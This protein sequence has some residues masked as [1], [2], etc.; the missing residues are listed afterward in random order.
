MNVPA[1]EVQSIK[2]YK[3]KQSEGKKILYVETD[4]ENV[5][6]ILDVDQRQKIENIL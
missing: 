5:I 2:I 6:E 1:E 4:E 3:T